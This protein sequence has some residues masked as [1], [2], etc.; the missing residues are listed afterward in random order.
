MHLFGYINGRKIWLKIVLNCELL[1]P[2]CSIICHVKYLCE[3][4]GTGGCSESQL[5]G[6]VRAERY[7]GSLLCGH[8]RAGGCSESQLCGHVRAGG[9]VK[10]VSSVS[11]LGLEGVL[12]ESVM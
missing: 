2:Y 12:R 3:H 6:H 11:M 4:V 8:V 9:C 10:R 5:C 1:T 7:S